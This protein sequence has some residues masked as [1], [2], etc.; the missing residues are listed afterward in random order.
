MRYLKGTID[1]GLKYVSDCE[2]IL[3]GYVDSDWASSVIEKKITLRCCFCLPSTLI[4]WLNRKNTTMAFNAI[5]VEYIA[6]CS[7]S[8]KVVW[9]RKLIAGLFDLKLEVT[10]IYCGNQ[11]FIKLSNNPMF[12][13]KSKS[14]DIR[15]HY[16]RDMVQNRDV[17][18][19]YVATNKNIDNV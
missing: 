16:I 7:S 15:Y 14:I 19:L 4:S 10:C 12:Y 13:D 8:S 6:S 3:H 2:V 17:K 11:S 1:Y 18:I 9:L 5:K